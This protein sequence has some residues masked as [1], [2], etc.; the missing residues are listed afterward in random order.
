MLGAKLMHTSDQHEVICVNPSIFDNLRKNIIE[1][2]SELEARRV[3][4]AKLIAERDEYLANKVLDASDKKLL[5][6]LLAEREQWMKQEP[7]A[8]EVTDTMRG[9]SLVMPIQNPEKYTKDYPELKIQPLFRH[10]LPA[11]QVP[12]CFLRLHEH[13]RGLKFGTDWNKGTQATFHRL[14][15]CKAASD[16]D[17]FLSAAPKPG[18]KS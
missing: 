12:E 5:D 11:Q 9:N 10:P 1:G 6:R 14:S 8:Y 18:D 17:A 13:A 15:L 7:V 2:Q 3:E 16:C 4:N